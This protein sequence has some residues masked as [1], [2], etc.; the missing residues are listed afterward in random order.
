[1]AVPDYQ[2]LMRPLLELASDGQEHTLRQAIEALSRT[3]SLT[4]ADRRELIPSGQEPKF[5]NRVGWARTYLGKAGLLEKAGRARFRITD[6]GREV[7]RTNGAKI[8]TKFLA[9]FPEFI[10]FRKGHTER[11]TVEGN[12]LAVPETVLTGSRLVQANQSPELIDVVELQQTPQETLEASYQV[13]R[14]E[15]AQ[16]LLDRVKASPPRFFERLVV[17]LLVAMGY[18]GS[19]RDA[20][21]AVGQS[22]D[23]GIDGIIKEDRLGL[24]VVYL[25]AKRWEGTVG[26][27]VVQAFAGSLEGQRARKGVFITTSQFSQDAKE[28]VTRIEKKIVLI[29]GEQLGQLMMDFGI[30]VTEVAT[31]V[32]KKVDGDYFGD[33]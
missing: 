14:R 29:D 20:G 6:R 33:E 23:G 27:P 22:G 24:D 28:Y 25:Q 4:D 26:R 16:E 1:M 17:D 21:Q 19:R 3:L 10:Q 11:V 15:L 13:L 18:G 5:D 32:V 30:G 2:S 9:Q 8:N 7:L 12:G 31:Y